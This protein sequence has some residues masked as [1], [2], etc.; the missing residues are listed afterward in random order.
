MRIRKATIKDFEK[1]KQIRTEFFLLEAS[2]DTRLN[3]DAVKHGLPIS[4]GKSIRSKNEINLIAEINGEI[5]GYASSEIIKNQSWVKYKRQ[6]HLYNLY[7]KPRYQRKGIGKKLLEKS[8]EWFKQRSVKDI[9]ILC[10][11]KNTLAQKLYKKYGFTDYM[12]VLNKINKI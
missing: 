8:L 2:T 1:F 12:K 10:Y 11:V 3:P 7:V 9:K 4:I 6:G 5:I